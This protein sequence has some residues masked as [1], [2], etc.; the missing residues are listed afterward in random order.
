VLIVAGSDAA[1]DR[2]VELQRESAH[3]RAE[4]HGKTD[5]V[6]GKVDPAVEGV[7]ESDE[8]GMFLGCG[9][10]AIRRVDV[11][12]PGELLR[13]NLLRRACC[14]LA[15]EECLCPEQIPDVLL[16]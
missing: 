9:G 16:L 12:E 10:F 14:E 8:P 13:A 11:L 15:G 2:G 1:F 6:R 5:G 4:Q 3:D 7:T